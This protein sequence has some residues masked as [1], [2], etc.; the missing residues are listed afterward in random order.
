[1]EEQFLTSTQ[2]QKPNLTRTGATD[3]NWES[4]NH[5]PMIISSCI[6]IHSYFCMFWNFPI[7]I[8]LCNLKLLFEFQLIIL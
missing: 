7:S 5:Q 8:Q 2:R 1:L 3:A 6:F 4:A